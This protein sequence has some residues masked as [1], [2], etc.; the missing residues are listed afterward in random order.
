[1][2]THKR[3]GASWIKAF[4]TG[5]ITVITQDVAC[6]LISPRFPNSPRWFLS[7]YQARLLPS[8]AHFTIRNTNR[9][10]G[11][12]V[13]LRSPSVAVLTWGLAPVQPVALWGEGGRLRQ[14]S[15][16]DPA[17]PLPA[18]PRGSCVLRRTGAV[19]PGKGRRRTTNGV[20]PP[21]SL[22]RASPP[23]PVAW[24]PRGAG[25]RYT[26]SSISWWFQNSNVQLTPPPTGSR[27]SLSFPSNSAPHFHTPRKER[28]CFKR[29][30]KYLL[31]QFPHPPMRATFK[32]P[33][34]RHLAIS[35][36]TFNY[37]QNTP[38]GKRS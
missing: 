6:A 38:K 24:G 26:T 2:K 29:F 35:H 1:M 4:I 36:N 37:L 8:R 13:P 25:Q 23:L 30:T 7:C 21:H 33:T 14:H 9:T 18:P 16:P 19:E 20:T 34:R 11:Q 32:M 31:S 5:P 15:V 10:P 27:P 17:S 12:P 22:A 3:L 28:K